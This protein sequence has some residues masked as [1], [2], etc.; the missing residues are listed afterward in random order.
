MHPIHCKVTFAP[1]QQKSPFFDLLQSDFCTSLTT[2]ITRQIQ[3]F[4]PELSRKIFYFFTAGLPPD[5]LGKLIVS[6]W[7]ILDLSSL[8][9]EHMYNVY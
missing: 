1:F 5:L 3:Q 7:L 4:E 6:G 9:R 8:V 2:L